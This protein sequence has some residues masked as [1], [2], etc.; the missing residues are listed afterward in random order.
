MEPA[1]I[2]ENKTKILNLLTQR[3]AMGPSQVAAELW[4][5]PDQ[6]MTLLRSMAE[7]NLVIL[8]SDK[9]S[10]D[11]MVVAPTVRARQIKKGGTT[12]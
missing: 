1:E 6:A 4:L 2:K 5:L 7:D 8:R 3:G 10:I 11:G 12:F 9:N